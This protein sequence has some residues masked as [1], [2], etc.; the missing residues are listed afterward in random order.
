MKNDKMRVFDLKYFVLLNGGLILW[1]MVNV[2]AGYSQYVKIMIVL[3]SAFLYESRKEYKGRVVF[4]VLALMFN[5]FFNV[6]PFQSLY[7]IISLL[8]VLV[9]AHFIYYLNKLEV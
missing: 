6:C 1:L 9:S 4:V 8:G 3:I 2:S 7:K 5:P